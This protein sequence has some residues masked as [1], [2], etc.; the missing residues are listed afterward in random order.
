VHDG[1]GF[2]PFG[3]FTIQEPFGGAYQRNIAWTNETVLA[4]HAVY[5]CVTLIAADIAKL[6]IKLVQQDANGIWTETTSA[7]FSPVLRKPNGFQTRIQFVEN[8]MTSKLLRGNTYVLKDYDER[9]TV[10][11]FY[12]L[13][14]SR[15]TP[16]VAPNGD[17]YYRLDSD[18]LAGTENQIVPASEII[19]DR[20]NCLF[21]PLVG[22]TPLMASGAAAN[23]GLK[24]E[25]NS[26][27]FFTDDRTPQGVLT[28]PGQIN[29]TEADR[30]SAQWHSR[31]RGKIAV[32][33]NG[34]TFSPITMT[35]ED[36]QLIEQ[37]RWT[38]E[39]VC[40]AFH[41][42]AFK[43]GI[44]APPT[45]ANGEILDGRYYSDCLQSHI[46]HME[47]LLDE[48]LGI[49]Q[50][51][52]GKQY[53]V[54]LDLDGLLRMDTKTLLDTL[55][56]GVGSAIYSPNEARARVDM[57]PVTGGDSPMLQQQN[58]SL[59]A[60]AERDADKPFAKAAEPAAAPAATEAATD[61]E[62]DEAEQRAILTLFRKALAA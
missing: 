42:P 15:V 44:G 5:A 22:T 40:S 10:R 41:V 23:V 28:V 27:K 18:N 35:A 58:F 47:L 49:T 48:A 56:V 6:R 12:V 43:V 17:V 45:Y 36:S 39:V 37:L 25:T 7:A 30:I 21:H 32:L 61:S 33:P 20:M 51:K 38:G 4:H 26:A 57:K 31:D 16:L 62:P 54:E 50:P 60:L 52:D 53:G 46:E 34:M 13:D 1:R 19:H 59:A 8:W 2:Y 29:Q 9:G 24:I 3:T 11:A 55:A 14:P